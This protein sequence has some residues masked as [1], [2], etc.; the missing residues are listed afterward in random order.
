MHGATLRQCRSCC[1]DVVLVSITNVKRCRSRWAHTGHMEA[2]KIR[3][4]GAYPRVG[5]REK[6]FEPS[7]LALAR[8]CSTAELFPHTHFGVKG[9]SHPPTPSSVLL[10]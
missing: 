3:N 4:P 9:Y 1:D 2:W 6:G 5:K 10:F 8:R 7:T